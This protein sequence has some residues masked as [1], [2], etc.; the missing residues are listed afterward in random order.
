MAPLLEVA[1]G[2]D[3]WTLAMVW[4][5]AVFYGAA[6]VASGTVWLRLVLA[7][8]AALEQAIGMRPLVRLV[9]WLAA[10]ALLLQWPLQAAVLGGGTL[11]SA[12][13]PMLLGMVIEG[14]Q[15]RRVALAGAGLLLLLLGIGMDSSRS[16]ALG[17]LSGLVGAAF[18]WLA[19]T[20]IGHTTA[21]P[22][23]GPAALL[24]LHLAAVALW[25]AALIVLHRMVGLADW[26][27]LTIH[28]LE[29]FSRLATVVVVALIAAGTGLLWSLLEQWITL[30]D[31]AYGQLLSIK[32]SLLGL[33]LLLAAINRWHL[34]PALRRGK[35]RAAQ[36]LRA[37]ILTE[38]VLVGLIL[39]LTALLTA[40]D[41]P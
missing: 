17:T 33:L 28:T 26:S 39:L 23:P 38:G 41:P 37:S 24:T 27:E 16:K 19:F 1:R 14:A 25:S 36:R 15:G 20:Q 30:L 3:A 12:F 5:A 11:A 22:G 2:L 35:P 7:L 34:V 4:V 32:I 8:P 29:R 31:T 40:T 6:L 9:T 18:V 10:A 21:A 13:D